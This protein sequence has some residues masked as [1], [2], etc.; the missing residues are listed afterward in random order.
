ML[1]A[2][3][4]GTDLLVIGAPVIGLQLSTEQALE[5]MRA[6]PGKDKNPPDLRSNGH[7]GGRWGTI[8]WEPIGRPK[9]KTA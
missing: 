6:K 8:N 7:C 3:L 4:E 2:A 1:A 9:R 5:N